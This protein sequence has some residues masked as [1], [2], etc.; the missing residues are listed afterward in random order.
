MPSFTRKDFLDAYTFPLSPV[1]D[2]ELDGV[3]AAFASGHPRAWASWSEAI[4][5]GKEVKS[6]VR[7]AYASFQTALSP[8]Q[9]LL[10]IS[11]NREQILIYD[12]ATK[13][14][15]ATL[16][17]AGQ[18]VFKPA[19][20]PEKPG[21]TLLSGISYDGDRNKLI[22]WDLDQH[23]RILDEEEPI[24]A[25]AFATKAIDSILPDLMTNHEWTKD[26]AKASNLQ[27]DFAKALRQAAADHRRRHHTILSNARVGGFGSSTFS[28]D[29][30]LLIY[31][32]TNSSTQR[33]MRAA[34]ELPQ[35]V[36]YDIEMNKEVYR[37]AGHTDAI[38]WS[39]MSPDDQHIASVAWDGTM[40]MYSAVTG[41]LEWATENSG[42]QSWA[43]AFTPDSQHI[44]WSSK[45]GRTIQVHLV[46]DGHRVSTFQGELDDWC[47]NLEWHPAGESLALCAGRHVFVWHPFEGPDGR[48]AQ[49]F[50]LDDSKDWFGMGSVHGVSW[51]ENGRALCLQFSDGTKLAYDTLTNAKEVF[52][53]PQGV[54][55]AWVGNGFYGV[56]RTGD[57][58]DFYIS[59][60]GDGKVRYWRTSVAA[61]PSWW[62]KEKAEQKSDVPPEKPYPETGKYVKITRIPRMEASQKGN[63]RDA[64]AEKGAHL[65]T[66][67]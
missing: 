28:S 48:I 1:H 30:K 3:P 37:L 41:T 22:L 53:R 66:A 6:E 33:S 4:D 58:P 60:D 46:A 2:F 39:A 23:G 52:A 45:G 51:M 7:R 34:E 49:H 65:W 36:V 59:V 9:K 50:L 44:V 55:T 11:L 21:Y 47:R 8:D 13:E 61:F 42:G 35:V 24:D 40:R 20:G 62:E 17:G 64:W 15:R 31:H 43:G 32:S 26:F 12:V 25:T 54:D 67:E 56:L 38:M 27:A 63:E 5:F 19:Q 57:E 18:V 14:L 10:A 29:G 16:E